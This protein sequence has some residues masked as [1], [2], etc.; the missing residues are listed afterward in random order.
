[1]VMKY[2]KSYK[3]FEIRESPDL[4]GSDESMRIKYGK[5]VI[6]KCDAVIDR[7]VEKY[8]ARFYPDMKYI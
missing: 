4:G 5:E 8:S 3:V 2:L 1:M 7:S 6:D